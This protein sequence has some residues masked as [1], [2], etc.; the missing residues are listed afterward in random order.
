M[1][2]TYLAEERASSL[3]RVAQ[4]R[5]LARQI[6]TARRWSRIASWAQAHARRANSRLG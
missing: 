3:R 2:D 1:F 6:V 5:R 4:E